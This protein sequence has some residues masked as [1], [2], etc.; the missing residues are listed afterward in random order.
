MNKKTPPK[1]EKLKT[2]SPT[3]RQK[4][5]FLKVKIH[6]Q[7]PFDFKELSEHLSNEIIHLLGLLDFSKAGVWLLKDKFDAENQIVIVKVST[8]LKDK[9][10]AS[11]ALI[12]SIN[13]K[14][15]QLEVIKVTST[16]KGLEK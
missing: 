2:L 10:V 6:S 7:S 11:L 4:K 8:K 5:R 9:L 3:L 14:K 15:V 12:E 13:N 16:L 1:D